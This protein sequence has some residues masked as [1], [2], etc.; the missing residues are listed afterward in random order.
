MSKP[1]LESSEVWL[2]GRTV[3]QMVGDVHPTTIWRWVK[4]GSFPP[5]V[6]FKS[7]RRWRRDQI[8]SWIAH[9]VANSKTPPPVCRAS[10]PTPTVAT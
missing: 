2:C 5:P 4:A 1:A 9:Q 6:Y 8:E 10:A 7:S 3:R